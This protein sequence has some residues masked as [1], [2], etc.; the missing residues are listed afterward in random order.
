MGLILRLRP[1]C[2]PLYLACCL[3]D[4]VF[5]FS[6]E[7]VA[8]SFVSG[9]VSLSRVLQSTVFFG[10]AVVS[11]GTKT[12]HLECFLRPIWH[13]GSTRRET[14]G[15]QARILG[16]FRDCHLGVFLPTLKQNCVFWHACFQVMSFSSFG[17]WNWMSGH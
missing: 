15:F 10:A 6:V 9:V 4:V 1:C 12:L 13:L 7:I 5:N 3:L 16:G 11:F 8:G 2:R 17:F 14:L